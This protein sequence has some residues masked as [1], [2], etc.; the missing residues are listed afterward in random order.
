MKKF[1]RFLKI[2]IICEIL[3]APVLAIVLS[4]SSCSNNATDCGVAGLGAL[5]MIFPLVFTVLLY[6]GIK[7]SEL[8]ETK[9][10]TTQHIKLWVF[11][12]F[13]AVFAIC[14]EIYIQGTS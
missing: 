8:T 14:F 5:Y 13:A 12:G 6:L 11:L 3:A 1:K 9:Y 4:S 7:L 2:A 10:K